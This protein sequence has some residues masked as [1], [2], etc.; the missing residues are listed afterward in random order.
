MS[1]LGPYASWNKETGYAVWDNPTA[2][3]TGIFERI[4][5]KPTGVI[6]VGLWDFIEYGCYTKLFGNN[7][8]GIEANPN[9]YQNMSKPVADK[10]GFKIFNEFV[11]R[12]DDCVK[13]FYFAEYGS[14]FYPGQ[15]EWNKVNSIKVKT[16][17]LSTLVE[18]NTIN[19]NNYD[20]L[21][22]DVE[23]AELDVL[24]GFEKHLDYINVIDIETSLDDRCKSG[25]S[26]DVIV[27]WLGQRGFDLKEMSS[28]YGNQAWGDSLFVRNNRDLAPFVDGNAGVELFGEDYLAKNWDTYPFNKWK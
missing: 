15:P 7:V 24:I 25:A 18:E 23:G 28:S 22:I 6:H 12:E 27:E 3:Y 9:I 13:N 10:W 21:N 17:T 14:S 11:Y 5:V 20:F 26:H 19:M 16:K 4:N 2:E 1:M 8:V